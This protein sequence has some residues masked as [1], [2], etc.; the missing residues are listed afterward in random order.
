MDETYLD[1]D[2][3]TMKR[4]DYLSS[5]LVMLVLGLGNLERFIEIDLG[6]TVLVRVITNIR[7]SMEVTYGL[8]SC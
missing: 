4:T 6:Q 1:R 7:G 2:G 8:S 5:L 3:Y